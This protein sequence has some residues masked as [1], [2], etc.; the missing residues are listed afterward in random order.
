MLQQHKTALLMKFNIFYSKIMTIVSL[1]ISLIMLNGCASNTPHIIIA[2]DIDTTPAVFHHSKQAQLN[3]IDMRTASHIVQIIRKGEAA[4]LISAHER[5]EDTIE[6]SLKK[7][8]QA[9]SLLINDNAINT[10]NISIEKAII[11]V[12]QEFIKYKVQTEIVLKVSV[13][14]GSQT[15]T[16]TFTNRGNSDGPFRADIAVLERNFNQGLANLIQQILANKKIS[17]ALK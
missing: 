12:D 11:S 15:L 4:T 14:N 10:I 5:L 3:V 16:N 8:W 9:Q 1:F 6:S 13:N 2:P 17:N 7:H